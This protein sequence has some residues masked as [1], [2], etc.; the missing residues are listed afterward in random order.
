MSK[1]KK[2]KSKSL[3][4]DQI[5]KSPGIYRLEQGDESIRIVIANV[6]SPMFFDAEDGL[7]EEALEEAWNKEKFFETG[8]ILNLSWRLEKGD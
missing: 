7:L 5:V 6:L 4:Y 8:E 1:A 2:V 3:T